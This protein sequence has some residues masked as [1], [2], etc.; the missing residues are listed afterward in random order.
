MRI[1]TDG[2]YVG[3]LKDGVLSMRTYD[4]KVTWNNDWIKKSINF[5][6]LMV[7]DCA[8]GNILTIKRDSIFDKGVLDG[9]DRVLFLK[10]M[11]E[12]EIE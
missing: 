12:V 6:L 7:Y 2:N 3:T 10:D 9:D 8:Q 11:E 4:D 1:H 5:D